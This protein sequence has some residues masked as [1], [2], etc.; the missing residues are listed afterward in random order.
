MPLTISA[1]REAMYRN[2]SGVAGYGDLL[3]ELDAERKAHQETQAKLGHA[4]ELYDLSLRNEIH[5]ILEHEKIEAKLAE[6]QAISRELLAALEYLRE[7]VR[8][9][10]AFDE[11][12][13]AEA[14][15][16]KAR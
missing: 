5:L 2:A 4:S 7:G 14:A 10:D 6:A 13:R 15:I 1:E 12:L 11:C 16:A 8:M 3:D 9:A